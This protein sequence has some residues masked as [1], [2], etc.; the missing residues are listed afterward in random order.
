MTPLLLTRDQALLDELGRLAAAA[1]VRPSVLDEP[2][3]VLPVWSAAPLVLLGADVVDEVAL[4]A[5]PRRAGVHVVGWS[6]CDAFRSALAVGAETVTELPG[7]AEW[8][9]G[10]LTDVG[11]G[12]R[13]G[14]LLGVVGGCGG[15]GATTLAC[16]LA[17]VGARSGPTMLVDADPLG[18]GQDTMLGLDAADGVRW[19]D[20]A[21]TSGR[22]GA[23]ALREAVPRLGD[24]GVLA[25]GR[26]SSLDPGVVRS[27]VSAGVRGHD[28]VVV[29]L[30][31]HGPL[32]DEL[33]ARCQVV[34][35]VAPATV[36][37]AASTARLLA[38]LG[39]QAPCR[40][41]LRRGGVRA[42]DFAAAAGAP[43]V[44]EV[45]DQRGLAEAVDLG[46]GPV[47]SRRARL[48]RA[49]AELLDVVA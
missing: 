47:R 16:A 19:G 42:A 40:I 37:A 48:A 20:L 6:G 39:A 5:P 12:E 22:L 44:A 29:D 26:D 10:L 28:L 7:S 18:P 46:L 35:V 3:A 11:E 21:G 43:V 8:L 45:P 49:A 25:F 31:R 24:L 41:A 14:R 30:P 4:A 13:V 33:A 17:Q 32:R 23:R 34:V 38:G 27:V 9:V 2:T 36:A 1:G 15:A